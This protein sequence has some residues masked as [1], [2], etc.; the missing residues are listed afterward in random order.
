VAQSFKRTQII[1]SNNSK[2][3]FVH[4]NHSEFRKPC[5]VSAHPQIQNQHYLYRGKMFDVMFLSSTNYMIIYPYTQYTL[6]T[7]TTKIIP[8]NTSNRTFTPV[9]IVKIERYKVRLFDSM[10]LLDWLHDNIPLYSI[11]FYYL[12]AHIEPTTLQTSN[13]IFTPIKVWR[14]RGVKV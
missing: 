7:F 9:K 13:K 12:G 11:H 8:S 6:I 4:R 10:Y 3:H 5:T 1:I 2:S 14:Y